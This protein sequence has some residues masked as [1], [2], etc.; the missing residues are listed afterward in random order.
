MEVHF[1]VII[2]H[3]FKYYK[4]L[5]PSENSLLPHLSCEVTTCKSVVHIQCLD[6]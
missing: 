3:N 5:T 4:I 6:I 1:I 2:L